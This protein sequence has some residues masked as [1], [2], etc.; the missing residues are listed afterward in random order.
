MQELGR[1]LEF[2]AR[3]AGSSPIV[4]LLSYRAALVPIEPLAD[5]SLLAAPAMTL[6]PFG[7]A[8]NG[9]LRAPL[10]LPS[11]WPLGETYAAQFVS[12]EPGMNTIWLSNAFPLHVNH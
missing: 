9:E 11:V 8:P 12:L 7:I 5:G 10:V 4:L 3:G 1:T 2:V 6:G